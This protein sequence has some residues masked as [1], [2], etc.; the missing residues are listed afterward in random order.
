MLQAEVVAAVPAFPSGFTVMVKDCGV[1]MQ[2]GEVEGVTIIVAVCTEVTFAALKER[3]PLPLAD[4]PIDG[5][6]F[7]QL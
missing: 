5:L 1:H 6:L 2:A 4:K 3:F 7:V